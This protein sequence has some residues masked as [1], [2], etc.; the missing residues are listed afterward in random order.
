MTVDA[1]GDGLVA[2]VPEYVHYVLLELLK[3]A[4]RATMQ[5]HGSGNGGDNGD[6]AGGKLVKTMDVAVEEDMRVQAR[7]D[8]DD[9]GDTPITFAE[10]PAVNISV[11]AD[12]EA[13][14]LLTVAD[15][16]GGIPEKATDKV[17]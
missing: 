16:G 17:S 15:Q 14:V 2:G 10:V 8:G 11:S 4:M 5:A 7:T 13:D 3:N 12:G 1:S 9:G 6:R